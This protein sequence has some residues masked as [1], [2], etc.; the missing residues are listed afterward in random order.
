[1]GWSIG[2]AVGYAVGALAP[3]A[4][5]IRSMVYSVSGGILAGTFQW[6]VLRRYAPIGRWW[7]ATLPAWGLAA[8]AW[9]IIGSIRPRFVFLAPPFGLIPTVILQWYFLRRRFDKA[10]WWLLGGALGVL[11]P[12]FIVNPTRESIYAFVDRFLVGV[13]GAAVQGAILG[14]ILGILSGILSGW[15]MVQVL[16]SKNRSR[17]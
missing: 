5:P 11:L 8:V 10:W 4:E 16:R 12:R 13:A 7:L 6:F 3:D 15:A 9:W 17:T 1:M 14:L 2:W